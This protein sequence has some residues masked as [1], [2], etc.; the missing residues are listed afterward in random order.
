MDLLANGSTGLVKDIII[1]IIGAVVSVYIPFYFKK[2][3]RLDDEI[4][5]RINHHGHTIKCGSK[6]CKP[7]TGD[8]VITG[9]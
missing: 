9:E 7:E 2:R 3:M 6:E 5:K 1:C 4:W 8:V